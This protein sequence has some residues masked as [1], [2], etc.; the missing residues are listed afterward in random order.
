MN[1]QIISAAQLGFY[2]ANRTNT[3]K[4]INEFEKLSEED[5]AQIEKMMSF[6]HKVEWYNS[7]YS[8]NVNISRDAYIFLYNLG[9]DISI[10]KYEWSARRGDFD[11]FAFEKKDV[12]FIPYEN[13]KSPKIDYYN[14]SNIAYHIKNVPE[15]DFIL[16][17]TFTYF[18]AEKYV[19]FVTK[20]E[21][22]PISTGG[23]FEESNIRLFERVTGVM[24]LSREWKYLFT[25]V[26]NRSDLFSRMLDFAKNGLPVNYK[27]IIS[28]DYPFHYPLIK[29]GLPNPNFN[30][31]SL[32]A[33]IVEKV[34]VNMFDMKIGNHSDKKIK[35][36]NPA[37][38]NA[39][40]IEGHI[41]ATIKSY[42][43]E[44]S[45][46]EFVNI[47][48]DTPEWEYLFGKRLLEDTPLMAACRIRHFVKC[49][50]PKNH[51]NLTCIA[52]NI[53]YILSKETIKNAIISFIE[54][55]LYKIQKSDEGEKFISIC[56]IYKSANRLAMS[57]YFVSLPSFFGT[58]QYEKIFNPYM[59]FEEN[60][61]ENFTKLVLESE[62]KNY[63]K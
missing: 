25:K 47:E 7:K 53:P 39:M 8:S 11:L 9:F 13:K 54:S 63:P 6:I 59:L 5:K 28:G 18:N 16:Q 21:Y 33:D 1:T 37:C 2:D 41:N 45:L 58:K 4:I 43:G 62:C 12:V 29:I 38:I 23:Y 52:S 10:N 55:E 27:S 61:I 15:T 32:V 50:L 46:S 24:F 17:D 36:I 51:E 60:Y 14:F 42:G 44:D 20:K 40:G 48:K 3:V 30:N 19:L 57:D 56:E 22:P 35:S 26:K 34:P 31:L 49:G